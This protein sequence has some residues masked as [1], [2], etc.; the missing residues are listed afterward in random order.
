MSPA[1]SSRDVLTGQGLITW[2]SGLA[3][4]HPHLCQPASLTAPGPLTPTC[5]QQ[6]RYHSCVYLRPAPAGW[7]RGTGRHDCGNPRLL[8]LI[9]LQCG[10]PGPCEDPRESTWGKPQ[11]QA[12]GDTAAAA[13]QR[14]SC[15]PQDFWGPEAQQIHVPQQA[16]VPTGFLVC[17]SRVPLTHSAMVPS[18]RTSLTRSVASRGHKHPAAGRGGGHGAGTLSDLL[19]VQGPVRSVCHIF[20]LQVLTAA[21]CMVAVYRERHCQGWAR[22]PPGRA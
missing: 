5:H 4:R 21:C 22:A 8:L 16:H 11:P 19:C 9:S 12:P 6:S 14:H 15:P 13:W 10:S 2:V 1:P 18:A 20:S 3:P 17:S 7:N